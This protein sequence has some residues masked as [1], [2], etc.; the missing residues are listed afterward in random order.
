[1][2]ANLDPRGCEESVCGHLWRNGEV[3]GIRRPVRISNNPVTGVLDEPYSQLT[4]LSGVAVQGR[5][6]T[7]A[8]RNRVHPM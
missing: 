3:D 8:G 2:N 7:Q 1:M 6:S 4:H 5:Q